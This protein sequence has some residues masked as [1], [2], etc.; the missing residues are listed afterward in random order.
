LAIASPGTP[1]T[2]VE[3][4][5]SIE[6]D[7]TGDVKEAGDSTSDGYMGSY[8]GQKNWDATLLLH[9]ALAGGAGVLASGAAGTISVFGVATP[10]AH[11]RKVTR[12]YT[13]SIVKG[14]DS[15]TSG[16]KGCAA[17]MISWGVTL[18]CYAEAGKFNA[19]AVEVGSTVALTTKATAADGGLVGNIT[20]KRIGGFKAGPEAGMMGF[21][22]EGVGHL[23]PT[24]DT[25]TTTALGLFLPNAL[26]DISLASRK[27]AAPSVVITGTCMVQSIDDFVVDI[28]G[29]D[30]QGVSIK[31]A[32]DGALVRPII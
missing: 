3:H 18:E 11:V 25:L 6:F 8:G 24:S 32:G 30:V 4:F 14:A 31:L 7:I 22:I 20:I 19:N 27:T 12:H 15:S 5:R 26:L 13:S 21:T 9:V 23:V 16:W 2:A 10:L 17:G 1:K 28:E 29:G